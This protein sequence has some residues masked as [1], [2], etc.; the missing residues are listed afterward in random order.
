M[1]IKV[2]GLIGSQDKSYNPEQCGS[3]VG[4]D[5]FANLL[6]LKKGYYH[7][8][9]ADRL[10]D[11]FYA[12]YQL[13][14]GKKRNKDFE[15]SYPQEN[16]YQRFISLDTDLPEFLPSDKT[17]NQSMIIYADWCRKRDPDIFV[18]STLNSISLTADNAANYSRVPEFTKI[19]I[20]DV[21]QFNEYLML[22]ALNGS[23]VT[24]VR[25]D[26]K[27]VKQELDCQLLPLSD[28]WVENNSTLHMLER[29]VDSESFTKFEDE[30]GFTN[31]ES[32]SHL[33]KG[34]YNE[35][36]FNSQG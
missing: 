1:K 21:R 8:K 18:T 4:K 13:P 28:C 22:K 36:P 7:L 27:R 6:V 29:A 19:V 31:T 5:E 26:T 10:R 20:S 24:V 2:I 30:L 9:F 23:L 3:G 35:Y 33:M 11:L 17:I 32:V 25:Q 15:F 16:Q 14:K 34:Y 12:E